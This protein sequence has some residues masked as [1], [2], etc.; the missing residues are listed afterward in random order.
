MRSALNV[1]LIG[2]GWL[3][4]PLAQQLC[5]AGH[6]V[7]GSTTREA[8]VPILEAQ[9]I[10]A[11]EYRWQTSSVPQWL[12]DAIASADIVVINIPPKRRDLAPEPFVAALQRLMAHCQ[13]SPSKPYVVFVSTTSVFGVQV[14]NVDEDT[15]P[16]PNTP[17]GAAHAQLEAWLLNHVSNSC[18]VRLAGLIDDSRHPVTSIVRRDIFSNGNQVVNLV[19][20]E[21]VI[22][23]LLAIFEQRPCQHILHFCAPKHPTREAYYQYS[24]TQKGLDF[25]IVIPDPEPLPHGKVVEAQKTQ[26]LLGFEY[27]YPSPFMM[28]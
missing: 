11:G 24:A 4:I 23:G 9:G 8:Q 19:H 2:C 21:D 1:G 7:F 15:P 26:Q 5:N 27:R 6:K 10:R 14:G 17:S 22:R 12:Q 3:G 25:P 18:V 13:N 16:C 20:K 28:L